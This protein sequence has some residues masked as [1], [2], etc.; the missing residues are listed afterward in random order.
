MASFTISEDGTGADYSVAT[1]NAATFNA[2]DE[3]T[4]IGT[5]TSSIIPPSSGASNNPIIYQGQ[6]G[7]LIAPLAA[8]FSI[9]IISKEWLTIDNIIFNGGQV[10]RKGVAITTESKNIVMTNL[11]FTDFQEQAIQMT[12]T[13]GLGDY[14]QDNIID[15]CS[16]TDIGTWGNSGSADINVTTYHRRVTIKNTT[17]KAISANR[18]VDAITF[19]QDTAD[20]TGH[21]INNINISGEYEENYLDFKGVKAGASGE[22]VT[23]GRQM[24]YIFI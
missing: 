17:H 3:L 8:I 5:I 24:L 10:G 12:A 13:A 4:I 11:D 20:G 18:G 21:V 7:T 9:S 14:G 19:S 6:S 1:H 15:N 23:T 22:T 2:G 16:F